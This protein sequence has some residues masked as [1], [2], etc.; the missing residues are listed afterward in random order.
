LERLCRAAAARAVDCELAIAR[1][2][3]IERP[4]REL[5]P[6]LFEHRAQRASDQEA[7]TREDAARALADRLRQYALDARVEIGVPCLELIAS[8]PGR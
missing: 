2:A 4:V 5:Q 8:E 7:H 3:G 1:A 6:G